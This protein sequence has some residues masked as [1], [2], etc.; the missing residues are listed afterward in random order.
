MISL[1]LQTTGKDLHHGC[2]PFAVSICEEDDS[3]SY[4]IWDV[5][6][7]TRNVAT[8]NRH[9]LIADD[10][11]EI[12]NFVDDEVIV[13]HDSKFA[14]MALDNVLCN[15]HWGW[16]DIHDTMLSAHLLDSSAN[17]D[18]KSQ[19]KEW[20]DFDLDE[21][22]LDDVAKYRTRAEQPEYKMSDWRLAG[23]GLPEMP[24]GGDCRV[25]DLWLISVIDSD[26]DSLDDYLNLKSALIL[27]LHRAH[28]V[29]IKKRGLEEIYEE[30]RK[31][32]PLVYHMEGAGLT[33][34]KD[35]LFELMD[36]YEE[37]A[38][39]SLEM[40]GI[41]GKKL[42]YSGVL[43]ACANVRPDGVKNSKASALI[44]YSSD[45]RKYSYGLSIMKGYERFMLPF[46]SDT[47][48]MYPRLHPVG[49]STLRWTSSDPNEHGVSKA[50]RGVF[51]PDTGRCWASL[52]Y[53]NLDLRIAAYDAGETE[54]IELFENRGKGPYFGSYHLL[55]F[56]ILHP[57]EFKEHGIKCKEVYADTLYKWTKA[58]NFAIQYGAM[59]GSGTADDAYHVEGAHAL[60]QGRFEKIV[61]LNQ[62][63]VDIA[64]ER[65]Y[66]ETIPDR[67]LNMACGYPV[68]LVRGPN[69][70]VKPTQPLSYR[71]SS[72]AMWVFCRA[73][74]EVHEYLDGLD[75]WNMIAMVHDEIILDFPADASRKPL[76][77][78][79]RIM[80]D[81]GSCI[82]V[83]L[84]VGVKLHENNWGEFKLL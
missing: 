47:H 34:S 46:N 2:N 83:P 59:E 20:L 3:Q 56:D 15:V 6:P 57:D 69:R 42:G 21:S 67:E 24:S 23:H 66:V 79:C 4:W 29:E 63:Q 49:S 76:G 54:M 40:A 35:R 71:V 32:L 75:G 11:D 62:R 39:D 43:D 68:R 12:E 81:K 26:D 8:P 65:G 48:V 55:I 72:A 18:L 41:I 78:I 45:Y 13:F 22:I 1:S 38:D 10:L 44:K 50:T 31:I 7:L 19:V 84:V 25:S 70:K 5:D 73:M 28:M 51:G 33:L 77:K 27:H 80:E 9:D 74:V 14:V 52:D 16:A 17:L 36:E 82:G 61:Q 53:S 64:N 30:R 37:E 60:I 58:G